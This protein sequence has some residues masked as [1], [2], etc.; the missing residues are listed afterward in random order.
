MAFTPRGTDRGVASRLRALTL[1]GVVLV[2]AASMDGGG[3]EAA[4]RPQGAGATSASADHMAGVRAHWAAIQADWP[5]NPAVQARFALAEA[6]SNEGLYGEALPH[7]MALSA[8]AR[9]R[10]GKGS[11]E[12][13]IILARWAE[14]LSGL[15]DD[16]RGVTLADP[17]LAMALR[18]FGP[19][20]LHTD[21][22]RLALATAAVRRARPAEA[23]PWLEASFDYNLRAGAAGSAVNRQAAGEV[24][25][26]LA[27]V[28]SRL[29]LRAEERAMRVRLAELAAA[30][31]GQAPDPEAHEAAL[32]ARSDLERARGRF[33]EAAEIERLRLERLRARLGD[34]DPATLE[35]RFDLAEALSL[36]EDT[37]GP[38][39]QEAEAI[40]RD[41]AARP[42]GRG[43]TADGLIARARYA[44]A[45]RLILTSEPGEARFD[46]GA[47]L[48]R[49]A[50]TEA[51]RTNGTPDSSVQMHM[52][53]LAYALA[54]AGRADE[55]RP[56]LD[57]LAEAERRGLVPFRT[58]SV[59]ALIRA[60]MA[61]ADRRTGASYG[62]VAQAAGAFRDYALA[63][64][65]G[66]ETRRTLSQWSNIFRA[67]VTMAWRASD[68][69]ETAAVD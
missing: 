16:I 4:H 24:G 37:G 25:S 55:A 21:R 27:S 29:N 65:D 41:L 11:A 62:Q 7:W 36:A 2:A 38:T 69:P 9:E 22:F 64:G 48:M 5:A 42:P 14:C 34:E 6:L 8:L 66:A 40:Y 17:G 31:V 54:R 47:G 61:L 10:N 33:V 49:D 12:D 45:E 44:L 35:A 32:K 53:V 51:R 26:V 1:A 46:E 39:I 18:R 20:S 43:E 28:Y 52:L 30:D 15:G 59:A 23:R 68:A 3:A 50:L 57:D 60:Q 56:L 19:D 67:Q 58:R 63:T 13:L